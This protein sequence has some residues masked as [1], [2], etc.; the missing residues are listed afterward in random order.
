MVCMWMMVIELLLGIL[1]FY[2][3][4]KNLEVYV[5]KLPSWHV[6]SLFPFMSQA[7]KPLLLL[8]GVYF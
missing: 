5:L 4:Y 6:K 8:G 2:I 1:L 7:I 3:K